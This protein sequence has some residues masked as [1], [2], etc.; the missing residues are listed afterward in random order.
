MANKPNW[1]RTPIAKPEL[2]VSHADLML[3]Q[4][5]ASLGII[6]RDLHSSE[7]TMSVECLSLFGIPD[8]VHESHQD[9]FERAIHPEDREQVDRSLQSAIDDKATVKLDYRIV[10][11]EGEL[12]WIQSQAQVR[13]DDSGVPKSLFCTVMDITDFKLTETLLRDRGAQLRAVTNALPDPMWLKDPNGVYVA[14]N[15]EFERLMD[16]EESG[17]TGK[18][19]YDLLSTEMADASSE[20]DRFA[21]A[22][23]RPTISQQEIT[24]ADDGHKEL[25]EVIKAPMYTNDGKPIGIL[26]VARDITERK[27]HEVFSELQAR[28]AGVLL[29]LPGVAESM[30]EEGFIQHCLEIM[31]DL[32]G[33]QV[34]FFHFIGDDQLS[35][36]ASKFSR[37][38]LAKHDSINSGHTPLEKSGVFAAMLKQR[39]P[40]L[41]NDFQGHPGAAD[42]PVG[43]PTLQ[44]V[45]NLPIIE[46]GKVVVVAGVGNK[47]QKYTDLD[48]ETVQLVTNDI[49]RIVQRQRTSAQLHKLAQ[50][51][52]QNPESIIITNL[53]Y[54]IEYL[55]E[56]FLAQSGYRLKELIGKY[57]WVLRS[58]KKSEES[59][60]SLK[61]AISEGQNWQGEFVNKRKDGSEYIEFAVIAPLR[62]PD[63]TITHYMGVAS[64]I[65]EKK[66][67]AAELENYRHNLEGLVDQRTKELEEAQ[68]RAVSAST[69]KSEFLANM[70]HEIRTPMNAIIGLTHLLQ[71]AG[72]TPEQA[73]SLLKIDSSAA[74]LLS[75]IN[76]VLDISKIEAG[77]LLLENADFSTASIFKHVQSM[78]R[79]Q[80]R[81]KGLNLVVDFGDI[82][83]W[84][85][86]DLTRLRQ[87]LLN[88]AGNA[89]KFS[90]Q[91]TITLR[92][93][94]LKK[95]NDRVL[96]RFEVED[97]GIGIAED[98]LSD[99]FQAFE[100]ADA[101]T[102]RKYGGSGLGLII[103]R[104]FAELMDGEA[105]VESE[106]GKGSTFW[107][108]AW[109]GIGQPVE[110]DKQEENVLDA[111]TTL[112]SSYKGRRILL[113]EDNAIN[114]EVA[115]ALLT[116][117]GLVVDTAVNGVEAVDM[118]CA[119]PYSLVLMDI[120]MPLMDGLEAT[121]QIRSMTGSENGI[122]ARNSA[123]PILA[124]TANVFEEDRKAC[125]AAGMDELVGKP[126]EPDKLYETILN[127]L[128]SSE[129]RA[130]V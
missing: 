91:G 99:L 64:D 117:A 33:S 11:P 23:G 34:A 50:V 80:I 24:Y 27:Q 108:T 57:P 51:V 16:T 106:L 30:D 121:R 127:W 72:P 12:R 128:L 104:R 47:D 59:Y 66:R 67:V 82:P 25:V 48:I 15:V 61:R 26:G 13:T 8:G 4:R 56:A 124:M 88:Y 112:S 76:D 111:R 90:E 75:I 97:T 98:K 123:I 19:D 96:V 29:E 14:C 87:A 130:S 21:M 69:A 55:N 95:E 102:T 63:G 35:I 49:W 109:L 122:A 37:R 2:L 58:G 41:I 20:N 71:H 17:I 114:A 118:V 54:E 107:F 129:T 39:E 68:L 120:Q 105:G 83:A 110:E 3:A 31:E 45:I 28:R 6:S 77:K 22:S 1:N 85:N 113:V 38:T 125:D 44:R 62:Q 43:F 73:K 10:L 9:A 84:L 101:S 79:E 52:E 42:L 78:L 53:D 46:N 86:G 115:V 103:T 74:H 94:N 40:L 126:V 119:N 5:I 89:V 65:T 60:R 116:R 7:L 100:Q 32:T 70:S 93:V 36:E 81:A 92:A 18:T